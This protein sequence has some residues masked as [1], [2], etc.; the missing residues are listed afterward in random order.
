MYN[1]YKAIGYREVYDHIVNNS[2]LDIELIKQKV[3]HYAKR[4]IT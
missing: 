3:R 4:Q 2:L 1:A